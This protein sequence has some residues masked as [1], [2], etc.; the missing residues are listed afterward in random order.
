MFREKMLVKPFEQLEDRSVPTAGLLNGLLGSLGSVA[1]A[2]NLSA[3]ADAH[4]GISLAGIT[5][6]V[7]TKLAAGVN[8]SAANGGVSIGADAKVGAAVNAN[9]PSVNSLFG[10]VTDLVDTVFADVNSILPISI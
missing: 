10:T 1:A 2:A 6:E 7:G 3:Y 4:A 9:L 5:T 8:A